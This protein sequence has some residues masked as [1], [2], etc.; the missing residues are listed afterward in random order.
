MEASE[1]T[2]IDQINRKI[3]DLLQAKERLTSEANDL[4]RTKANG[5]YSGKWIKTNGFCDCENYYFVKEVKSIVE[6]IAEPLKSR[7]KCQCERQFSFTYFQGLHIYSEPK[8]EILTLDVN[9]V[10]LSSEE[11]KAVIERFRQATE[12]KLTDIETNFV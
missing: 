1:F 11:I 9:T 8:E 2:S 3:A 10:I 6:S 5:L 12:S 7:F 4:A